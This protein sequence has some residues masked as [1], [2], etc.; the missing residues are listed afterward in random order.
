MRTEGRKQAVLFLKK[1]N[2]KNVCP[3]GARRAATPRLGDRRCAARQPHHANQMD[4]SFF[5]SFFSKK[6]L[7]AFLPKPEPAP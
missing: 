3:L 6:E 2:Q 5:G 7:L 4:K 1:K